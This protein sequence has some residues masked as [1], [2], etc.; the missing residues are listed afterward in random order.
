MVRAL[1]R[2]GRGLGSTRAA[3]GRG[4]PWV[5]PAF[6]L[7][8][9][10]IPL[11]SFT[12]TPPH[13]ATAPS[14]NVRMNMNLKINGVP[15]TGVG[16]V[17]RAPSYKIEGKSPGSF[18]LLTLSSCHRE[19]VIEDEGSD[20][21]YEY[22]PDLVYEAL[23]CALRIEG[24]DKGNGRHSLG[25]IDFEDSDFTLDAELHCNGVTSNPRGVA[26]CQG[27]A[28]LVQGITF[29]VPVTVDPD[30][31][32]NEIVDQD[33]RQ[34]DLTLSQGPC[35]YVFSSEGGELLRLSTYGYSD[36][37]LEKD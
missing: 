6:L 14:P 11:P 23:N 28:G 1:T 12:E 21:T 22:K 26:I 30:P 9:C 19:V 20:F 33:G 25:L 4:L 29:P 37:I 8:G 18:D 35:V 27:R 7:I 2:D 3:W 16:V 31:K 15:F 17:K 24:N 34:F 13:R 32:C 5:G 10:T 36:V